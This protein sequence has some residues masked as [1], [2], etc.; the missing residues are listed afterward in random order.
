MI[1]L[2]AITKSSGPTSWSFRILP[3][4]LDSVVPVNHCKKYDFVLVASGYGHLSDTK[5]VFVVNVFDTVA[6]VNGFVVELVDIS[7]YEN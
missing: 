2:N 3:L 4:H 7:S 5:I 1:S 6:V